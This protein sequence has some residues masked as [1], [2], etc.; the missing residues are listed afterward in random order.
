MTVDC[1]W[2]LPTRTADGELTWNPALFPAG[3]PALAKFIHGLGLKFGVYGDGGIQT[4]M[5]GT[6]AQAGS[7][8]IFALEI[9]C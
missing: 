2:S 3:Y 5:T 8:G 6:P 9:L 4:C 1:G 7:L